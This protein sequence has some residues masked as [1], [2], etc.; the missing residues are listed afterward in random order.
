MAKATDPLA[1]KS[2]A[3]KKA[4]LEAAKAKDEKAK[5]EAD[6]KAKAEADKKADADKK[7]KAPK[8]KKPRALVVDEKVK[9][10]ALVLLAEHAK[11][12]DIVAGARELHKGTPEFKAARDNVKAKKAELNMLYA[13]AG[14]SV[15]AAE[16][17][18]AAQA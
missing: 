8:V 2:D 11:L 7:A 6:K 17:E 3:Q 10:K 14:D 12:Q 5:A 9:A 1:G 13:G 16:T 4:A 18:F 15:Q